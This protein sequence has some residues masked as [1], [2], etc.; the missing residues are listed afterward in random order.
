LLSVTAPPV[1]TALSNLARTAAIYAWDDTEQGVNVS[2]VNDG[3]VQERFQI[4]YD[5]SGYIEFDLGQLAEIHEVQLLH[6][7]SAM[8][9]WG[10]LSMDVQ[11][12]NAGCYETLPQGEVRNA[13]SSTTSNTISLASNP[14]IT[15]KLRIKCNDY[16]VCTFREINIIGRPFAGTRNP[17]VN[18]PASRQ[19]TA[20]TS[21]AYDYGIYFPPNYATDTNKKYPLIISLHGRGGNILDQYDHRIVRASPEGFIKQMKNTSTQNSVEAIVIAPHC[22]AEGYNIACNL[23]PAFVHKIAL[24]AMREYRIDPDRIVAAGLS[25]GASAAIGLITNYNSIYAGFVPVSYMAPSD[26][27][28]FCYF[29]RV[30][31]WYAGGTNDGHGPHSWIALRNA[32]PTYCN[33]IIEGN[34]QITSY[35]GLGH[36]AAVWD[37]FFARP[38]VHQFMLN[39][40]RS[41]WSTD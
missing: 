17:Q 24:A 11:V 27:T 15:D 20:R 14:Y 6:G 35:E 30:P 36:S 23:N 29:A 3:L 10:N 26:T 31:I 16:P 12:N 32:L 33:S 4:K 1:S 40:R 8:A 7:D 21:P 37:N 5:R 13:N 34:L 18:C 19:I 38:E 25:A 41:S 28:K 39:V 22:N 2:A 9:R